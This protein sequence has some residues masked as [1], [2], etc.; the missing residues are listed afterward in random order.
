MTFHPRT[1][2]IVICLIA[3][4]IAVSAQG[5]RTQSKNTCGEESS[6]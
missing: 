6:G 5:S 3:F 2:S 4:Q 1:P